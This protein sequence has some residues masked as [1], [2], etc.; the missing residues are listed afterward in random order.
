VE[1]L[2]EHAEDGDQKSL[3][4]DLKVDFQFVPPKT[5]QPTYRNTADHAA[6]P[7]I[8]TDT[9]K[10]MFGLESL[11]SLRGIKDVKITGLPE[12]YTKCLQLSI[13]GKGGDVEETDWPLVGTRRRIKANSTQWKKQQVSTRKWHQPTLNWKEFA[14]RNGVS[15]PD[16]IDKFWAAE[17]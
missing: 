15:I 3:L 17:R 1:I 5:A 6:D 14:E 11:S 12:W 2:K 8:P 10:F 16:D 13:Q 7:R 9:E 4:E